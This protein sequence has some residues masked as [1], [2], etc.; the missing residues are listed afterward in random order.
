MGTE[1]GTVALSFEDFK[2]QN[3]ITYWLAS[4]FMNMLGYE[5]LA[6]FKN[7][8]ERAIKACMSLNIP[9]EDH[10]M[11]FQQ[12]DGKKDYKLT[13]FACYLTAMNG[14]PKKPQV[15]AAQAYFAHQTRELELYIQGAEDVERILIRD[16][17]KEGNKLL[18]AAAKKAG[19]LD[20]ARFQNAGY[21]GL[22]NQNI[23]QIK[24]TK[25]FDKNDKVELYEYMGRTELA[26]NLFRVT[27]TEEKLKKDNVQGQYNAENT[28][29][30][31]ARQVREMVIENVGIPP[32]AL[33]VQ[34]HLKD[35]K[36]GLK[37]GAKRLSEL[38]KTE[39]K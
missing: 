6:S 31:V 37:T 26:A 28:H 30:S 19:V 17:L 9:F 11:S 5:S 29:R 23:W 12:D 8:I 20:H 22:Y 2:R 7:P 16:E 18:S 24:K 38:D 36:K 3:G 4:E 25:G 33:P 1:L 32:E 35:V 34:P 21:L 13:R 15:A 14:D 27:M 10:F 39:K